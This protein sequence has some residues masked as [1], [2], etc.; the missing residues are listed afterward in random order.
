MSKRKDIDKNQRFGRLVVLE[1]SCLDGK[2][3]CKCDCGNYTFAKSNQLLN[4]RKSSCGCLKQE[5]DHLPKGEAMFNKVFRMYRVNAKRRNIVFEI[6]R[7]HFRH[8]VS[9]NCFYCN[10]VPSTIS[11]R[12][13]GKYNGEFIYNG[14]DRL[15]SSKG[16]VDGN[17]V[18]CCSD[19]NRAKMDVPYGEFK[20]W[21]MRVADFMMSK[22]ISYC[23]N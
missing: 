12:E 17:V 15:D 14:I 1:F 7:E 23:R 8:L 4:G 5:L 6:S 13:L 19:C 3:K 9:L 11:R 10:A 18:P 2:W 21:I 20:S 16:Y 22:E